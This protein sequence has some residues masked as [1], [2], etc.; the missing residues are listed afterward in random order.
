MELCLGHK[1]SME[2]AT[3]QRPELNSVRSWHIITVFP[4]NQPGLLAMHLQNIADI[5]C[6]QWT[7]K[8]ADTDFKSVS[9]SDTDTVVTCKSAGLWQGIVQ[10][11]VLFCVDHKNMANNEDQSVL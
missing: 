6:R 1:L 4:A 5:R 7:K 9:D 10:S 3:L 2:A 11:T 8:I